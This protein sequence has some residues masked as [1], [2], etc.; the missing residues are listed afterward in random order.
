MVSAGACFLAALLLLTLP[1][2][3]LAAAVIAAAVHEGCHMAAIFLL[4]GK[5]HTIR[6]GS[7]G[8]VLEAQTNGILRELVCAAAGP[9]GSLSLLLLCHSFPQV[10]LC[11][12]FQGLFN[13]LPVYPMDGGR[14]LNCLLERFL[15]QKAAAGMQIAQRL[16]CFVILLLAAAGTF[17]FSL[18]YFPVLA[19]LFLLLQVFSRKIPCKQS[20][21]RVQ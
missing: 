11:G 13:L 5:I 15:P 14:I 19:A 18:G 21:I 8:A 7:T 17:L 3:Y 10:A 9:A 16:T 12:L 6:F 4:G 1:L 2:D 20:Q